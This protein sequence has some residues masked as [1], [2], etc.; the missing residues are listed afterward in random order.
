MLV[1]RITRVRVNVATGIPEDGVGWYMIWTDA[2]IRYG[3]T[4]EAEQALLSGQKIQTV[5]KTLTRK[6][7]DGLPVEIKKESTRKVRVPGR[8]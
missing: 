2:A 1:E 3:L 4:P 8:K 7:P 5:D 6:Y